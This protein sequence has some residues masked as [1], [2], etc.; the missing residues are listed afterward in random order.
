MLF[1]V[2]VLREEAL[3]KEPAAKRDIC[4][5]RCVTKRKGLADSIASCTEL[6]SVSLLT[7]KCFL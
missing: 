5:C 2:K 7:L 3:M 6:V 4:G 1:F